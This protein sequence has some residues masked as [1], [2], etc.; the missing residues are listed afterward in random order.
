MLLLGKIKEKCLDFPWTHMLIGNV[1]N[2]FSGPDK[3][4][5]A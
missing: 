3:A 2:W 1:F 5:L 4:E